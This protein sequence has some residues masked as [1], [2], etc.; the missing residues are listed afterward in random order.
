MS[1]DVTCRYISPLVLD[2]IPSAV[3]STLTPYRSLDRLLYIECIP[4]LSL[5]LLA[6]SASHSLMMYRIIRYRCGSVKYVKEA[7][8]RSEYPN[9]P[10]QGEHVDVHV[11]VHVRY[12]S[13]TS[14]SC[15]VHVMLSIFVSCCYF[16]M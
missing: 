6:S 3:S 2:H 10:I 16:C 12:M 11:H 13:Y 1:C 7:I 15:S 5:I 9:V 8:I 4:S 14:C